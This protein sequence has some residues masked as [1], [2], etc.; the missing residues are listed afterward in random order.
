MKSTIDRNYVEA[1]EANEVDEEP[2]SV[3]EKAEKLAANGDATS[4]DE[5][6]QKLM[7]AGK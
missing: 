2:Q 5:T 7:P 1:L 3:V 4:P 6:R